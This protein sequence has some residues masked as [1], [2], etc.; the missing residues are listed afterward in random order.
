MNQTLE[1]GSG[2]GHGRRI[3]N[4]LLI[5]L[6]LAAGRHVSRTDLWVHLHGMGI[7]PAAL[8]ANEALRFCSDGLVDFLAAQ[9]IAMDCGERSRLRAE[10]A[11]YAARPAYVALECDAA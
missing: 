7:D 4:R 1:M 6:S 11:R 9:E 3:L 5:A 8:T 2:E 10:I